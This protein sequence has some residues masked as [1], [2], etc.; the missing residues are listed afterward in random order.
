MID[1]RRFLTT[2]DRFAAGAG[3]ELL[4]VEDGFARARLEVGPQHLNAA[5]V[6][7]GGAIFTLA[8][9]ASAAASNSHGTVA[10]SVSATIT[11]MKATRAGVL[12]AEAR[13]EG[14]SRRFSSCTV[15]VTDEGGALVAILSGTAYR[16]D[17]P[18][19]PA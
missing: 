9:L 18:M 14:L 19:P 10:L 1:L 15:R 4:E 17:E 11:F 5:G 13:E 7:Q 3:V 8:D 12:V 16:K 6:V 2:G